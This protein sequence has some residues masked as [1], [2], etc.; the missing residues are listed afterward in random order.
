[1]T[2]DTL[3]RVGLLIATPLATVIAVQAIVHAATPVKTWN[4]G[5][6]LTA[7]DL[8]ANFAAL[9]NNTVSVSGDQTIAG[10][11]KFTGVVVVGITTHFADFPGNPGT[12]TRL[13]NAPQ[14]WDCSCP[15]GTSVLAGGAIAGQLGTDT[16][17]ESRPV[18]PGTWRFA[19]VH[20]DGTLI[21]CPN[22]SYNCARLGAD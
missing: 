17:R 15:A 2:K 22:V 16:V 14:V 1:M 20:Q 21:D 13:P 8:N 4:S 9:A 6:T 5:E 10:A 7:A 3:T 11:K 12:C 18:G 19:C